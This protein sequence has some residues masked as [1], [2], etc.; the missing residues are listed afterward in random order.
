VVIAAHN[1]PQ[2]PRTGDEITLR[3]EASD[4][5]VVFHAGTVEK[6]GKAVTA[7]GRVLCA[8][9]L[10]DTVRQAQAKAYEL[11]DTISF[12]GMQFRSDIGY[13]AI[14]RK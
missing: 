12:D 3:A 10:G 2:T 5:A 7:G 6:N 8:T 4:E 14:N 9:A 13:R 11:I 1:Y